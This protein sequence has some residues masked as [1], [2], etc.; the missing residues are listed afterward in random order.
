MKSSDE[1]AE[2]AEINL[3]QNLPKPAHVFA[4]LAVAAAIKEGLHVQVQSQVYPELADLHIN[5]VEFEVDSKV[6]DWMNND[7]ENNPR[8]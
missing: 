4:M 6:D 2:L 1:Y 8:D 5:D 3:M 7:A